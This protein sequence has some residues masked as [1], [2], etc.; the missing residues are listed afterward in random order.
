VCVSLLA[1]M[2]A[3]AQTPG[4]WKYTIATDLSKIPADMRVNFPTITFAACRTEADFASGR[5]FGLQTLA[6]SEARCPSSQF[7]RTPNKNGKFDSL[8]FTY[9]CDGGSTLSGRASGRVEATKFSLAL[10]SKYSPSVNGVEV[11]SQT[12]RAT[13]VGPCKAPPDSDLLKVK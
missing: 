10:E 6:S 8:Q 11:I 1:G 7:E 9:A 2:N 12:M 3:G 4:E 5:A 13:L